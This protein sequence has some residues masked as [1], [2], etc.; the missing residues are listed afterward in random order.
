MLEEGLPVAA[1]IGF[2]QTDR[3]CLRNVT[4]SLLSRL[5]RT[6][7]H[8][9]SVTHT[10]K[11]LIWVR[12]MSTVSFACEQGCSL[13]SLMWFYPCLI[14]AEQ[15]QRIRSHDSSVS[16][17]IFARTCLIFHI[18]LLPVPDPAISPLLCDSCMTW[19]RCWGLKTICCVYMDITGLNLHLVNSWAPS[20]FILNCLQFVHL[21]IS[22]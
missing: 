17:K 10:T 16:E 12:L 21:N 22:W 14:A 1:A 20:S 6:H 13:W 11:W 3:E 2:K 8:T 19:V 9:R 15:R 4:H 18:W 5:R 7:T